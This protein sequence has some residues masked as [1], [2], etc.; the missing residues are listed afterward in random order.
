VANSQR[1]RVL[2]RGKLYRHFRTHNTHTPSRRWRHAR[3]HAC[4]F[5]TDSFGDVGG[6][7]CL[8]DDAQQS[9]VHAIYA[10]CATMVHSPS[11]R[12]RRASTVSR[13]APA[14]RPP[15]PNDTHS[16]GSVGGGPVCDRL[17][18]I[19]AVVARACAALDESRR[20]LRDA[21]VQCESTMRRCEQRVAEHLARSNHRTQEVSDRLDRVERRLRSQEQEWRSWRAWLEAPSPNASRVVLNDVSEP[22]VAERTVSEGALQA[23]ATVV[24][25]GSTSDMGPVAIIGAAVLALLVALFVVVVAVSAVVVVRTSPA[26]NDDASQRSAASRVNEKEPVRRINS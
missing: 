16:T 19:D 3:A 20:A 8:R 18:R 11:S 15:V 2:A 1:P 9:P 25:P 12:A 5:R 17:E 13:R 7:E 14:R 21:Q 10:R 24:Q 23:D 4:M 22:K 6:D 26:A